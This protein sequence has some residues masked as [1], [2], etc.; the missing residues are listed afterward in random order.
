MNLPY[1]PG[2]HMIA[3]PVWEATVDILAK[4]IG[5]NVVVSKKIWSGNED[6]A[7]VGLLA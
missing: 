1:L 3:A 7:T 5:V 6:M 4:I 2:A